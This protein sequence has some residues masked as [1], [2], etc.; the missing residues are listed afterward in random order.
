MFGRPLRLAT[1]AGR[2]RRHRGC[3]Q[4]L[5]AKLE[6]GVVVQAA[7]QQGGAVIAAGGTAWGRLVD[8]G[9]LSAT[10]VVPSA[11][12]R[13]RSRAMRELALQRPAHQLLLSRCGER[14]SPGMGLP[15]LC[16]IGNIS[17]LP[18]PLR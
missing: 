14:H 11:V 9:G 7:S 4:T 15:V 6:P 3:G 16:G 2:P 5:L 1:Y 13:A 18:T 17:I 10:A 12:E 8:E